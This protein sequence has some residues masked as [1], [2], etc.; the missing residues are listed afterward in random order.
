VFADQ[1]SDAA[2]YSLSFGR[3]AAVQ[4]SCASTLLTL[5]RSS[6]MRVCIH[7]RHVCGQAAAM[8]LRVTC[9]CSAC[10]ACD[11][12]TAGMAQVVFWGNPTTPCHVDSVDYF[13]SGDVMEVALGQTHYTEQLIR[14]DG[15]AIW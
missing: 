11:C 14:L 4:V 9:G 1:M 8:A 10:P 12:A 5:P 7:A 2:A 3:F 15:Q 13:M 6:I